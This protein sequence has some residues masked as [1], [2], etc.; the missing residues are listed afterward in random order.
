MVEK[1]ATVGIVSS[2]LHGIWMLFPY[3]GWTDYI[4]A[5]RWVE[6][7]LALLL[8]ANGMIAGYAMLARASYFRLTMLLMFMSWLFLATL[9][10]ATSGPLIVTW[11][12]YGTVALTTAYVYL[13]GGIDGSD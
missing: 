3:W 1:V 7:G 13:G 9:S 5:P 2:I 4:G 12:T 8:I 10:L 6:L 11:L